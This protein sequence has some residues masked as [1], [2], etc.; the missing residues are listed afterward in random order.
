MAQTNWYLIAVCVSNVDRT[1]LL[2][3]DKLRCTGLWIFIWRPWWRHQM[4]ILFVLL[5]L[6]AG[7][8]PVNGEIPSQ[9]PVMWS[10]DVFYLRVNK[11]LSKQSWGWWFETL[12]RSLG[13]HCYAMPATG[14]VTVNWSSTYYYHSARQTAGPAVFLQLRKLILW[15]HV[16]HVKNQT[17]V[18]SSY[19][20]IF[21]SIIRTP[22]TS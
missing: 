21:L 16:F 9:R 11:R 22:D 19:G 2:M 1:A 15:H 5:V 13:R 6:C 14:C 18:P 17:T 7:N 8:S 3:L 12:F 10:F 20:R 4:D